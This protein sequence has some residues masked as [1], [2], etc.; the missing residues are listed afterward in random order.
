MRLSQRGAAGSQQQSQVLA[1]GSVQGLE[2]GRGTAA[3]SAGGKAQSYNPWQRQQLLQ[4]P[5]FPNV[6]TSGMPLPEQRPDLGSLESAQF[7]ANNIGGRAGALDSLTSGPGNAICRT[8]L[9]NTPGGHAAARNIVL[10]VAATS[11]APSAARSE[12]AAEME[13]MPS[14]ESQKAPGPP[15]AVALQP[16][17]QQPA[18]GVATRGLRAGARRNPPR[19]LDFT[20]DLSDT[21]SQDVSFYDESDEDDGGSRRQ[22]LRSRGSSLQSA[23]ASQ[24]RS[25]MSGSAG[26]D[27]GSGR[28][29]R[30]GSGGIAPKRPR[31]KAL[32]CEQDPDAP[33]LTLEQRR[34]IRRRINNRASARRVR[35]KREEELHKIS[36]QVARLDQER[37]LLTARVSQTQNGCSQLAMQLKETRERWQITCLTNA[38]LHKELMALR[39]MWQR[40]RGM[41]PPAAT[42]AGTVSSMGPPPAAQAAAAPPA[43]VGGRPSYGNLASLDFA[44]FL[45]S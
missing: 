38:T 18:S 32:L 3:T 8:A 29:T 36:A 26:G 10:T 9:F 35:Q 24:F 17:P 30:R 37:Q 20:D 6:V 22:D 15:A 25:A 39:D 31:S 19:Y 40:Q 11:A 42:Q 44:N 16:P 13:T 21:D 43:S 28:E 45:A 1:R 14:A 27:G 4:P 12:P 2:G 23:D 41:A 34:K 7:A 33:G 5:Y